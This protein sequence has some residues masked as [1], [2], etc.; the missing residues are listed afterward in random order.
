MVC[1][2]D[3]H[4]WRNIDNENDLNSEIYI[5]NRTDEFIE[6]VILDQNGK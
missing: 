6:V 5:T 4:G 3:K 2:K 1:K